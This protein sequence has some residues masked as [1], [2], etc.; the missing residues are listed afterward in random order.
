MTPADSSP[1]SV[2]KDADAGVP[3]S[4]ALSSRL[5]LLI[6]V[7]I[8]ISG[9]AAIG[10]GYWPGIMI[11]D[12]RWQYQQVVD[13][14][15][16][17][18]HPPLMAWIWRRLVFLQ[19]GPAPMLILQ[20]VLYWTGLVLIAWWLNRR[21]HPR[22]AVAAV[23]IGLLP[24]PFALTGTVTKDALMGGLLLSAV[25]LIL[26]KALV[27]RPEARIALSAAA[28]LALLAASAVRFNGFLACVPLALVAVPAGF[29]RTK[30]RAIVT[31]IAAT[32]AFIA[33]GP[34]V[35]ALVKAEK[36]DVQLS[37]IIFDLGGITE[38]SGVS[39]FPDMGI[40]DPVAVNR[41]CY[42]PTEW[43]SY[44]DWA[45]RPCP[46]GFDRFQ[47][48]IDEGD[49]SAKKLW[50]RAIV[51]HPIA[52]A[53]HRLTHFNLS[54]WFLVPEGPDFTAWSQS[55]PNPWGF[56]VRQNGVVTTINKITDAVAVT[57]FGWPIF[58][59]CVALAAL[60][61]G[62]ATGVR[63]EVLAV[64]ASSFLYGAGY[65]IFGVA[66]GMRYHFWTISGAALGALLVS[67][68]LWR[69]QSGTPRWAMTVAPGV[70][71]VPTLMAI[72]ARLS[73]L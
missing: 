63:A 45:T 55:V 3:R 41:R 13:N 49:V 61:L 19:P 56:Q 11:D 32:C 68:E 47:A 29:T 48:L 6:I 17:D 16:E 67:E 60:V 59:I 71:I 65:L 21:G 35:A 52:Y 72:A 5:Y 8:A 53:E 64:A 33:I 4:A 12:A 27:Q 34:A 66:A 50:V 9:F 28:I 46:L 42:D 36:T 44:S 58:W 43:D 30:V 15:Y 20:L 26:W 24:A 69:R 2:A 39:Q 70:V 54:T 23:L 25:G 38:H 7:V 73:L 10:Y 31:S 14:S 18:W 1:K 51:S 40:A 57:P 37:L 22:L 62:I